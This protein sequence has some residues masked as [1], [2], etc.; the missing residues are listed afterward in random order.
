M[1]PNSD[2]PYKFFIQVDVLE[3]VQSMYPQLTDEQSE[4][5]A[6]EIVSDW[7]LGVAY[8]FIESKVGDYCDENGLDSF[9]MS[10]EVDEEDDN[11]NNIY[12]IPDENSVIPDEN[13]PIGLTD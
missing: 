9:A 6:S 12:V 8:D 1:M 2:D 5:V 10:E 7:D 4:D 3:A 13:T 11:T